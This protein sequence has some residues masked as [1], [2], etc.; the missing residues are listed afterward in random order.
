[1]LPEEKQNNAFTFKSFFFFFF[2]L[3]TAE[4]KRCLEIEFKEK[5]KISQIFSEDF[6]NTGLLLCRRGVLALTLISR[7]FRS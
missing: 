3:F 5:V 7:V 4:E 1:M 2:F 6:K